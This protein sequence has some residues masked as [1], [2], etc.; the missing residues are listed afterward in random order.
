MGKRDRLGKGKRREEEGKKKK[1][2]HAGTA[3]STCKPADT[4]V[5]W[6]GISHF[7]SMKSSP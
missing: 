4:L 5:G 6:A 3:F 1:R 7:F 2:Q